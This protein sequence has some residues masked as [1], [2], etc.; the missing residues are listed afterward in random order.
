MCVATLC[1]IQR[2]AHIFWH[3]SKQ[4][5]HRSLGSALRRIRLFHGVTGYHLLLR[6]EIEKRTPIRLAPPQGASGRW[7]AEFGSRQ[8]TNAL[9]TDVWH[10]RMM[11]LCRA[12]YPMPVHWRA[13]GR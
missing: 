9:Q 10:Q 1:K 11:G 4:A 12:Y 2:K 5:K 8:P 3:T 6:L 13:V 7:R